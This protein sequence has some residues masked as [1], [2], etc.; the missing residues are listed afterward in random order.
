M[1]LPYDDLK[2][3]D[4]I[5]WNHAR[6]LKR[7]ERVDLKDWRFLNMKLPRVNLASA[8]LDWKSRCTVDI[9]G[10]SFEGSDLTSADFSGATCIAADFSRAT[11]TN[12]SF[13][14]TDLRNANFSQDGQ[15]WHHASAPNSTASSG[16]LG[17]YL[18]HDPPAAVSGLIPTQFAGANLECATLPSDVSSF[19]SLGTLQR[20]I[21]RASVLLVTLITL[22]TYSVVTV[23]GFQPVDLLAESSTTALPILGVELRPSAFAVI[24]ATLLAGGYIYFHYYLL[25]I[26]RTAHS[27]P[28]VF[29]D[30]VQLDTK[31]Q[32]WL[33]TGL[34][35]RYLRN[36][37]LTSNATRLAVAQ[38][39][40]SLLVI[41]LTVPAA[42]LLMLFIM[43]P[44]RHGVLPLVLSL[45]LAATMAM[46]LLF[47]LLASTSSHNHQRPHDFEQRHRRFILLLCL[48]K[49]P[50]LFALGAFVSLAV[51]AWFS[52]GYYNSA[53]PKQGEC[54]VRLVPQ[55]TSLHKS[56]TRAL[57]ED[58]P[59]A[60]SFLREYAPAIPRSTLEIMDS[61][62]IFLRNG[63]PFPRRCLE[64]DFRSADSLP[65]FRLEHLS[66]LT[67]EQ[68]KKARQ[69]AT[70]ASKT[71]AEPPT[72]E[73]AQAEQGIGSAHPTNA[74]TTRGLAAQSELAVGQ[75]PEHDQRAEI[76]ARAKRI[77]GPRFNLTDRKLQG[78]IA[79][80]FPFQGSELYR[81]DLRAATLSRA[82]LAGVIG[83]DVDFSGAV[84]NLA[85]FQL[86]SLRDA[87]F[88][89]A[90]L[91]NAN[92][93]WS[94]LHGQPSPQDQSVPPN[95][96]ADFSG[97]NLSGADFRNARISGLIFMDTSTILRSAR[98]EG[99]NLSQLELRYSSEN[100][101][102]RAEERKQFLERLSG[103]CLSSET[104]LPE[105]LL[106]EFQNIRARLDENPSACNIAPGLLEQLHETTIG[107]LSE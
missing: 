34:F 72:N 94:L 45:L 7:T 16:S 79:S 61:L 31:V 98:L 30:G 60:N 95:P 62:D 41:W 38:E 103:A 53:L 68:V 106:R 96:A 57:E 63:F 99:V 88:R 81:T 71:K 56:L 6:G 74:D 89:Q 3:G 12:V 85:N 83:L 10:C 67:D 37:Y 2:A 20:L 69:I 64:L 101:Q 49:R 82:N 66:H 78:M 70:G 4:V 21:G 54:S 40:I 8:P 80:G 50:N 107:S 51:A 55:S 33:T 65:S 93:T 44:A 47:H 76:L 23:W 104:S 90:I 14:Q 18:T 36:P 73:A 58:W 52:V 92:F 13:W 1:S 26:W 105:S 86:A 11:L 29:P 100:E 27:L 59:L 48:Q 28:A 43:L 24:A 97:A 32:Y 102:I 15:R 77:D 19:P 75:N 35:R 9:S 87:D 25:Q 5:R 46:A 91:T 42:L 22:A 84:L 39:F 17:S